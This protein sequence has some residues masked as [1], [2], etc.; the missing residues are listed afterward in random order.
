M[1]NEAN[2]WYVPLIKTLFE[3]VGLIGSSFFIYMFAPFNGGYGAML[4]PFDFALAE[5][6]KY[7]VSLGGLI[8]LTTILTVVVNCF[9]LFTHYR[10]T[11]INLIFNINNFII[12]N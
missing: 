3:F 8:L 11:L 1:E 10:Q 6:I 2:S 5:G 7:W 12:K 9:G 4:L